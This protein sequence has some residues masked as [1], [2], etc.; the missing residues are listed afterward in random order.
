MFG[1]AHE[2][3]SVI[4]IDFGKFQTEQVESSFVLGAIFSTFIVVK[5][6]LGH[7]DERFFACFTLSSSMTD[8]AFRLTNYAP[9]ET[10]LL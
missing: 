6:D 8:Y 5:L 4:V 1:V 10:D 3:L 2:T 7:V 9:S